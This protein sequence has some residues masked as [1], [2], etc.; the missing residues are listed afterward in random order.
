MG[1]EVGWAMTQACG[2]A[3]VNMWFQTQIE[4]PKEKTFLDKGNRM[5]VLTR[6]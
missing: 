4:N 2:L 6:G 5:V 3:E 1:T